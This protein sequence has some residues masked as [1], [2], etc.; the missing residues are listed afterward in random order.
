MSRLPLLA[1]L[2]LAAGGCGSDSGTGPTGDNGTDPAPINAVY[3]GT[4]GL[5]DGHV[6]AIQCHAETEL[7]VNMSDSTV[8]IQVQRLGVVD[9][10]VDRDPLG[11]CDP[12]QE[13]IVFDGRVRSARVWQLEMT[14]SLQGITETH[15]HS[16]PCVEASNPVCTGRDYTEDDGNTSPDSLYLQNLTVNAEFVCDGQGYSLGVYAYR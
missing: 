6:W 5:V 3:Q 7:D 8:M 16:G 10:H 1:L 15:L 9:T 2:L 13:P 11:F 14:P 4:V 12:G